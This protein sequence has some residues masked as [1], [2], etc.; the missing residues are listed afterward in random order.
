[1]ALAADSTS[2]EVDS[3]VV[4][5]IAADSKAVVHTEVAVVPMV[6]FAVEEA[7]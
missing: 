2:V 4:A 6:A 7:S 3:T 1:M 5:A